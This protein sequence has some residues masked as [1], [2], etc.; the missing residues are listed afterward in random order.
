VRPC[1]PRRAAP[2]SICTPPAYKTPR[3]AVSQFTSLFLPPRSIAE[4]Q[5][6]EE[7]TVVMWSAHD[8]GAV[9]D[10]TKDNDDDMPQEE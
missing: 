4:S 8:G 7:A 9:V 10:L 1:L 2:T 6:L 3:V 5:P